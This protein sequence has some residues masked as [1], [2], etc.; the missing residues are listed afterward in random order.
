MTSFHT[1]LRSTLAAAALIALAA[2]GSVP[3]ENTALIEARGDYR[4]SQANAQTQS[5]AAA[6]LRQAGEALAKAEAAQVRGDDVA[7]VNHLSYLARQ[8]VAVAR[9]TGNRKAAEAQVASASAERDQMRLAARTREADAATQAAATATQVASTAIQQ[10]QGATRQAEAAMRSA[11]QSQQQ[12]GD[13]NQ[14]AAMLEQQL[15]ELNAK[16]TDRG[17]IVTMGDVLFDTGRAELRSGGMQNLQRLGAF[18]KAYPQRKAQIEGYTDSVGND[19]S[20]LALSSRRAEAVM[21]ALRSQGVDAGQMLAQG[22]GETHPVATNDEAAGRQ[23]NRRVEVV[24]SDEQG[25]IAP[26]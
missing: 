26:R 19:A 6:E 17:M 13:A 10:A 7:Q 3:T 20:N 21:Q 9:E 5:L 16:K 8:R 11:S 18:L 12:A 24:L 15:R 14:R 22:F 23:A 2:C 25:V 1:P 4:V